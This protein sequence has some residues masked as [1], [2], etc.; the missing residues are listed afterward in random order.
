MKRITRWMVCTLCL[1]AAVATAQYREDSYAGE[2]LFKAHET[3]FDVFGTVSVGQWTIENVS[4][5]RIRDNGRLGMG[6]GL[7]HFFTENIGV[8][9]DAYTESAGHS[10]VDSASGNMIF[11]FPFEKA[12]VAPYVYGGG[13]RL[14]DPDELWIGQVGGGIDVR[15]TPRIGMFLD[16]RYVF[17]ENAPD[18]GLF[19]LGLRLVF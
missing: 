15:F 18:I 13:G 16:G 8:G 3:S 9:A 2:P 7:N 4:G 17:T 1:P 6:L 14:F 11:R 5:D 19:R 10:F 12:R